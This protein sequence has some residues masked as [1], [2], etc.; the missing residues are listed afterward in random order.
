M[1]T[2]HRKAELPRRHSHIDLC[3]VLMWAPTCFLPLLPSHKL[4]QDGIDEAESCYRPLQMTWLQ[5]LMNEP[6][7][8]TTV[9]TLLQC[10]SSIWKKLMWITVIWETALFWDN[11]VGEA[12]PLAH[13]LC[14]SAG[15]GGACPRDCVYMRV[16]AARHKHPRPAVWT[17]RHLLSSLAQLVPSPRHLWAQ[18]F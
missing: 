14:D 12:G 10:T 17:Q 9:G 15:F 7:G 5:S 13:R 1:Y 4:I 6:V 8:V 16:G 3:V 18:T 2:G 11:P